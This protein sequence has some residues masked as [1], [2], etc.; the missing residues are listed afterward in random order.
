[1]NIIN[2]Y[3]NKLE[4]TD[5]FMLVYLL[6]LAQKILL[7]FLIA[8]QDRLK[9]NFLHGDMQYYLDKQYSVL[10]FYYWRKFWS[11]ENLADLYPQLVAFTFS[12]L[13]LT[14]LFVSFKKNGRLNL[15]NFILLIV[16]FCAYPFYNLYFIKN[17]ADFLAMNFVIL[18]YVMSVRGF[19]F[20][21]LLLAL[22]IVVSKPFFLLIIGFDLVR[23]KFIDFIPASILVLMFLTISFAT[24]YSDLFSRLIS[25]IRSDDGDFDHYKAILDYLSRIISFLTQRERNQFYNFS[26]FY[27]YLFLQS[28]LLLIV[29]ISISIVFLIFSWVWDRQHTLVI[30]LT[31]LIICLNAGHLRYAFLIA[32]TCVLGRLLKK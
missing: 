7:I 15:E 10:P 2:R 21:T 22:L 27:N 14:I 24:D 5:I 23:K 4:P 19:K 26:D 25:F 17:T 13:V 16:F 1:M 31:T 28:W 18:Y 32:L 20:T 11:F 12:T 9:D 6:I 29:K 3:K 8:F 30:I